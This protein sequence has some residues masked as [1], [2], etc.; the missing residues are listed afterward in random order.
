M[1]HR[2]VGSDQKD[3]ARLFLDQG[4]EDGE[5]VIDSPT[6][7]THGE[8]ERG[9]DG[10]KALLKIGT[11]LVFKAKKPIFGY[12]PSAVE[13]VEIPDDPIGQMPEMNSFFGTPVCGD[14]AVGDRHR[15][16]KITPAHLG[17][18]NQRHR[19]IGPDQTAIDQVLRSS[20]H[21][22]IMLTQKNRAITTGSFLFA[23]QHV[24][25]TTLLHLME[26]G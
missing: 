7:K 19:T 17:R 24:V 15:R 26:S 11:V 3:P 18:A 25:N 10:R 9:I 16:V 1:K 23:N 21:I 22:A 14:Q 2:I 4:R 5:F 12:T 8:D 6:K 13:G 20:R